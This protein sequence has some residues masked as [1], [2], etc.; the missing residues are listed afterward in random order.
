[1]QL[2]VGERANLAGFAL[3]DDGGFIFA[4]RGDVA[5]EAVVGEID[6]AADKP[7]RPRAIPFENFFPRLE[8]VQFTSDLRPE[9]VGILDRP[10]IE[11]LVLGQRL[12]VRIA[13]EFGGRLELALLLQYGIDAGA[14]G[15]GNGFIGHKS[16]AEEMGRARETGECRTSFY[17]E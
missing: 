3:P 15:V 16:S 5:V 11:L 8:P 13:A 2:L 1:M 10:L 6:F 12:N 7:F 14:L 9:F 17:T 4:M